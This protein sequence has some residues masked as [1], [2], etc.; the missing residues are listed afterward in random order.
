MLDAVERTLLVVERADAGEETIEYDEERVWDR[1]R[2][3]L[4]SILYVSRS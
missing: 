1:G 2:V 4:V 3:T